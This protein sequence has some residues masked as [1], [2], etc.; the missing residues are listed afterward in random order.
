MQWMPKKVIY[1]EYFIY[2]NSGRRSI[3]HAPNINNGV[4]KINKKGSKEKMLLE[5]HESSQ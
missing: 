1:G 5:K 2:S 4:R 3:E